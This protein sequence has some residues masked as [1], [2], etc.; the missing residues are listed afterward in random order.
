[1]L[2][3]HSKQI[4]VALSTLQNTSF[5]NLMSSACILSCMTA[6]YLLN[7]QLAD[8]SDLGNESPTHKGLSC[9]VEQFLREQR[10]CLSVIHDFLLSDSHGCEQHE[11]Y[12]YICWPDCM[13]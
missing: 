2:K 4:F 12:I 6:S 13:Q 3:L 10:S 9:P 8:G 1:M 11:E 7:K 5:I